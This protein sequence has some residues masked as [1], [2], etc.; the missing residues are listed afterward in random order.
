MHKHNWPGVVMRPVTALSLLT[1]LVS[2]G[3]S[4]I[5]SNGE[6]DRQLQLYKQ[7]VSIL[8]FLIKQKCPGKITVHS[9]TCVC[10][11]TISDFFCYRMRVDIFQN[12]SQRGCT[13]RNHPNRTL[14]T[15]IYE[16]AMLYAYDGA[17][18]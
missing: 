4:E 7:R 13:T 16:C 9:Y 12:I 3:N 2:F 8:S 5:L 18:L 17:V 11:C 6:A 15:K 10:I 14:P 1:L